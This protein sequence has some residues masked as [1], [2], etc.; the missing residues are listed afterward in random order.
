MPEPTST[1]N[2][3][4]ELLARGLELYGRSEMEA[5]IACWKEVLTLMPGDERAIDYLQAAGVNLLPLTTKQTEPRVDM[6][7]LERSVTSRSYGNLPVAIEVADGSEDQ[8]SIQLPLERRQALERLVGE[9]DFEA[10]LALA[11]ELRREAPADRSV[12]TA[13]QL[14]KERLLHDYIK[15]IGYLDDVPLVNTERMAE[16]TLSPAARMVLRLVDG[17]ANYSDILETCRQ[18]PFK[19]ARVLVRLLETGVLQSHQAERPS[20]VPC[21]RGHAALDDP[22]H[23]F[24]VAAS[25][26]APVETSFPPEA[27]TDV[28]LR[29]TPATG[30]EEQDQ[31]DQLRN[32]AVEAYL[33]RNYEKAIELFRALLD[34]APDD[35]LARHSI[36]RLEE[37]VGAQ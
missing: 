37:L 5:A 31:Q 20:R 10:A 2:R 29:A 9:R 19:V 26:P 27:N 18:G 30:S 11:F 32:S 17:I 23:V 33:A 13:I 28:A 6:E 22:R 36:T 8:K 12:S 14:L 35:E 34:A 24:G 21:T 1:L 7:T 4:E 16:V 15:R 3:V 25:A